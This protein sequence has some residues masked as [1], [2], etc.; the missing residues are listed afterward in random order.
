MAGAG[1]FGHAAPLF[2]LTV[3]G[4]LRSPAVGTGLVIVTSREGAKSQWGSW[5]RLEP[6][7]VLG[8]AD[9]GQVLC[10]LAPQAGNGS[11]AQSLCTWLGGLPLALDLAGSYLADAAASL[12]PQPGTPDTFDAY[13]AALE[14]QL[15]TLGADSSATPEEQARRKL[16][17]TWELSLDL[18]ES[19][20]LSLARPLLRL[21]GQH[22]AAEAEYRAVIAHQRAMVGD[23][24]P[25][26]LGTRHNLALVLQDQGRLDEAEEEYAEVLAIRQRLLGPAHHDTVDTRRNLGVVRALRQGGTPQPP[27]HE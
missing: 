10:D 19:R 22:V 6:V 4:W 15:D 27:S 21:R 12:W 14:N 17:T 20:G 25:T 3:R 1:P 5:A 7:P 11:Q 8:A 24:H 9:G 23:A 18:L 26:T 16:T 2:A 13:Q